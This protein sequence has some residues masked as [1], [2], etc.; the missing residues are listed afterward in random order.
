MYNDRIDRDFI[1]SGGLTLDA[2][3]RKEFPA[4]EWNGVG[5]RPD[6]LSEQSARWNSQ[7]RWQGDGAGELPGYL[8]TDTI[9][10]PEM[11]NG[12]MPSAPKGDVFPLADGEIVLIASL[13]L[14]AGITA[15][16]RHWKVR[17]GDGGDPVE[18]DL[19]VGTIATAA[20]AIQALQTIFGPEY[21][22][23]AV[24][25]YAAT[26][27]RSAK[28]MTPEQKANATLEIIETENSCYSVFGLWPGEYPLVQNRCV[29]ESGHV[30][31]LS[32]SRAIRGGVW[33]FRSYSGGNAAAVF[34][35]ARAPLEASVLD[36]RSQRP[37]ID[38]SGATCPKG[39]LNGETVAQYRARHKYEAEG[40]T[41]CPKCGR[42]LSNEPGASGIPG[43]GITTW[44]YRDSFAED[45]YIT[46][47]HL[48]G[49]LDGQSFTVT[50]RSAT[51][52][53]WRPILSVW[54]NPSTELYEWHAV[55]GSGASEVSYGDVPH[56]FPLAE[57][58][59]FRSRYIRL[60]AAPYAIPDFLAYSS[61]G[62]CTE[63]SVEIN[64]NFR[65]YGSLP[66]RG[67]VCTLEYASEE[68]L[69]L[70]IITADISED[71]TKLVLYFD[72]RLPSAGPTRVS[73]QPISF[74][75][76]FEDFRVYGFHY[77]PDELVVTGPA[78]EH[79]AVFSTER[80]QIALPEFPTQILGVTLEGGAFGAL[81]LEEAANADVALQYKIAEVEIPL[82][83]E[84]TA[85]AYRITGGNWRF[86]YNRNRIVLPSEGVVEGKTNPDGSPI[87]IQD[88][89]FEK[90]TKENAFGL[91]YYPDR[92]MIRYW[93]GSGKEI[94]LE[95]VAE[96]AGPSY[97]LE[98]G[99]IRYI[100]NADD[101]PDNGQSVPLPMQT[102]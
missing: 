50:A 1:C 66:W 95:A 74:I 8:L 2:A 98:R 72:H 47:F 32:A 62:E 102:G 92:V 71:F 86:D 27:T 65:E 41:A 4:S 24:S 36:Y 89:A 48:G 31:G 15:I 61:F 7:A 44:T 94:T 21:E 96:D 13:R 80:H 79:V 59:W 81:A 53:S 100:V 68:P 51:G 77:L 3:M 60:M 46:G 26:I 38:V 17:R 93:S 88:N 39:C 18:G 6:W 10:Y 30:A 42:D 43:D 69:E 76:Q 12:R 45:C 58:G 37:T 54:Y 55:D 22:I 82:D 29:S 87:I 57:A 75:G 97:Q 35:L 33:S 40:G 14:P 99:S 28:G 83:E 90:D 49:F 20:A 73:L 52:D 63:Y 56:D 70:P 85:T 5:D 91:S 67:V 16:T 78:D 11:E 101:L 25:D 64:G 23:I 9:S 34:D 19:P 84:N